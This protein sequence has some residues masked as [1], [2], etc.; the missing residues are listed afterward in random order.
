MSEDRDRSRFVELALE[1]FGAQAA[2]RWVAEAWTAAS[3][4]VKRDLADKVIAGIGRMLDEWNKN[5][6]SNPIRDAALK[7]V[8]AIVE[9]EGHA[10][11]ERVVEAARQKYGDKLEEAVAQAVA[12]TVR[13]AHDRVIEKLREILRE[14]SR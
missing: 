13:S 1:L 14:K 9:R 3:S 4:E 10:F 5:E 2:E 8:T 6:W 11:E 7:F 12:A